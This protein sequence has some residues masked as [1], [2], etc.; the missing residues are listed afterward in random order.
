MESIIS[1][2]CVA[3]QN[4]GYVFGG[5]VRDVVVPRLHNPECE[6]S[7]HDVDIWFPDLETA[8]DFLT[9]MGARLQ[10][11]DPDAQ[12]PVESEY[13]ANVRAFNLVIDGVHIVKVDV[14]VSKTFPANDVDISMLVYQYR[15]PTQLIRSFRGHRRLQEH[16]AMCERL[17]QSILRKEAIV[18]YDYLSRL[19]DEVDAPTPVYRRRCDRLIVKYLLRGWTLKTTGG[20]VVNSFLGEWLERFTT[21][22]ASHCSEEHYSRFI[23]DAIRRRFV[24][25]MLFIRDVIFAVDPFDEEIDLLLLDQ[26]KKDEVDAL[27]TRITALQ[28]DHSMRRYLLGRVFN[29]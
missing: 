29:L 18:C 2:L 13:M 4:A 27:V 7:Y 23:D 9:E 16:D 11:L 17:V 24:K 10:P 21:E 3:G 6:V 22:I 25:A 12:P 1:M 28:L 20:A 19:A 5:F 15:S 8:E 14:V 26:S